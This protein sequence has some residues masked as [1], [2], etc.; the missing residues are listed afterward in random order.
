MRLFLPLILLLAV[1]VVRADENEKPDRSVSVTG[2]AVARTTPDVITW[3]ISTTDYDRDL[4]RAKEASD[5]KLED[6]L[7]LRDEL[8]V[9]PEDIQTGRLSVNKE[10]E[11]DRAG[12]RGEFKG[13]AV[14][15]SVTLKQRDVRKFDEFVTKLLSS[16]E[17]EVSFSFESSRNHAIRMDTRIK[18]LGAARQKAEAMTNAL[19]AKLGRVMT[20][21][22]HQ[23]ESPYRNFASNTA[24]FDPGSALPID[25]TAGTFAPGAIE[26]RVSVHVTF[27]IE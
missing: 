21:E 6:I 14:H 27:E 22:E 18:A 9:K 12:N 23:P 8:D 19:G 13:F 16:A 17:M 3:H 26:I 10:Y 11:R 4:M 5:K 2:T 7:E 25:V 1:T 15:R 20:I 24:Y